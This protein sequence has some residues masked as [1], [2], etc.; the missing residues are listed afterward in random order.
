VTPAADTLPLAYAPADCTDLQLADEVYTSTAVLEMGS[1]SGIATRV[2][3]DLRRR[4]V[5]AA[6]ELVARWERVT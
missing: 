6:R 5:E 2:A 1:P 3:E 4:R